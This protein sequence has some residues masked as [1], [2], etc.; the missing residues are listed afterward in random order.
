[1]A[2][3]LFHFSVLNMAVCCVRNAL[4]VLCDR[5]YTLTE[6]KLTIPGLS[7]GGECSL[8]QT[9]RAPILFTHNT[10][11]G[12]T[13]RYVLLLIILKKRQHLYC[14]KDN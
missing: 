4:Y 8:D 14:L 11:T 3:T 13:F 10:I 5:L 12:C 6:Y 9:N 7:L 2:A 1:M